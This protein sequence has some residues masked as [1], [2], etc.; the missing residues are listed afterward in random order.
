[1]IELYDYCPYT[2]GTI[3]RVL[4][5]EEL[6]EMAAESYPAVKSWLLS[7]KDLMEALYPQIKARLEEEFILTPR[8]P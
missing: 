7:D 5:D 1:M 8:E 4:S 2:H 3:R 6:D